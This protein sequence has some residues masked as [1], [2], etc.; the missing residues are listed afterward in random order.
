VTRFLLAF[1]LPYVILAAKQL[2]HAK[3]HRFAAVF[4]PRQFRVV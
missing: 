3:D 4:C 1:T 2:A